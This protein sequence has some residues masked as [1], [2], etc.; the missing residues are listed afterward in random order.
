ML[1]AF[2]DFRVIINRSF[3][4]LVPGGWMESQEIYPTIYCDDGTLDPKNKFAEWTRIHDEAA[5]KL[6]KPLRIA[7]KLK[8]WYQETGFL[9]PRGS[10]IGKSW[11]ISLHDGLSGPTLAHFPQTFGWTPEKT[12]SYLA[13]VKKSMMDRTV[14]AYQK[15]YVFLFVL[16]GRKASADSRA[17]TSSGVANRQMK[18]TVQSIKRGHT[19]TQPVPIARR[20]MVSLTPHTTRTSHQVSLRLL[21]PKSRFKM[22]YDI[23]NFI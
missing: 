20:S 18:K 19:I 6:G 16:S 5:M 8:K 7:N 12:K 17:D 2:Y 9:D 3:A 4:N 11:G 22:W 10:M 15:V 23:S 1:G 21:S 13:D 14:H